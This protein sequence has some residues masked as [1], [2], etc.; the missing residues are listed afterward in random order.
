M[1]TKKIDLTNVILLTMFGW[2]WIRVLIWF[3]GIDL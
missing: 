2:M 1:M 3:V